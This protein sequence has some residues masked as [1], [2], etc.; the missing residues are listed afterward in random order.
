MRPDAYTTYVIASALREAVEKYGVRVHAF[1]FLSTHAHLL[2]GVAGCRLDLFMQLLKSRIGRRLN[3]HRERDGAFFKGRYR[4][5]PILSDEA[6]VGIEQYVHQQAVHH[7]LVERATEWPG[8]CSYAAVVEGRGEVEASWFDEASWREAGARRDERATFTHATSVPLSALPHRVGSSARALRAQ[9]EALA[10]R[11]K[12]V[13]RGF[14]LERRA[15]GARRLPEPTKYTTENPNRI[16]RSKRDEPKKP[17][18]WA[19]GSDELVQA[20]RDGYD[21]AMIAYEAA[22]ARY[23]AEGALCPFPAGT[24]PPRIP[25]PMEV[26]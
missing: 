1:C 26:I 6:A 10:L 4:D 8:L 12:D 14:A 22:S 19:H 2:L 15:S 5:E 16:A 18:P 13:E 21:R 24:F 9:R 23:R 7:G 3:E 17:Q 20:Y 11:M 25:V